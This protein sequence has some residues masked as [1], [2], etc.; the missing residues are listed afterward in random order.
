MILLNLFASIIVEKGKG[1]KTAVH[2]VLVRKRLV[3]LS[4]LNVAT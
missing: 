1:R 4:E 3:T 2:D